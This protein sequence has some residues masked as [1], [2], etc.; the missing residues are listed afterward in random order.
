MIWVA[1][2]SSLHRWWSPV[3]SATVMPYVARRCVKERHVRQEGWGVGWG[4]DSIVSVKSECGV[5]EA[6]ISP[7]EKYQVYEISDTNAYF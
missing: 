6:G 1:L 4:P 3:S 7:S 2:I 5:L